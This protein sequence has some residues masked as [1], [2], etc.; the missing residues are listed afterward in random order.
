MRYKKIGCLQILC[1]VLLV[2]AKG[3]DLEKHKQKRGVVEN[4]GEGLKFAGQMFGKFNLYAICAAQ[5]KQ[6]ATNITHSQASTLLPT[7]RI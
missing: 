1:L 4:F 2:G 7:W 3:A 5:S 6:L